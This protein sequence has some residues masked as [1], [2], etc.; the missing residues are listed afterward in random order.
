MSFLAILLLSRTAT[1][2]AIL[3][4]YEQYRKEHPAISADWSLTA[5]GSPVA[6]GS[7]MVDGAKRML[8][9]AANAG[10]SYSLSET[11]RGVIELAPSEQEYEEE[12]AIPMLAIPPSKLGPGAS[13][14]PIPLIRTSFYFPQL[15]YTVEPPI[16]VDGETADVVSWTVMIEMRMV[17]FSLAVDSAGRVVRF[18]RG[19]A[20]GGGP[21]GGPSGGRTGSPGMLVPKGARQRPGLVWTIRDYRT[22]PSPTWTAFYTPLPK[23][24]VPYSMPPLTEIRISVDDAFPAVTWKTAG[25]TLDLK[26]AAGGKPEVIVITAPDCVPSQKALASLREIKA[27]VP[28]VGFE[29]VSLARSPSE[30]HGLPY[31]ATGKASAAIGET[32]TPLFVLVDGTGKIRNLWTGFDPNSVGEFT[33]EISAA[34]KKLSTAQS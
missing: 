18:S 6:Q 16:T 15:K 14:I 17:K 30:A 34:V 28:G 4:R 24:Y 2:K 1:P 20:A 11:E 25:S 10:G 21:S 31:D 9:K 22:I 27:D 19:P 13:F 26:A 32:S 33:K 23:G 7:I 5:G 29:A 12:S 8:F 3:G